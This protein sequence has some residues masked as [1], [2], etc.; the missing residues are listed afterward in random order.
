MD[1]DILQMENTKLQDI[2]IQWSVDVSFGTDL[3]STFAIRTW[4]HASMTRFRDPISSPKYRWDHPESK[5]EAVG[6]LGDVR[7]RKS[8]R[9]SESEANS[10]HKHLA[11]PITRSFKKEVDQ[12]ECFSFCQ[13]SYYSAKAAKRE[14]TSQ[15]RVHWLGLF[16]GFKPFRMPLRRIEHPTGQ[17]DTLHIWVLLS[18]TGGNYA[19]TPHHVN[20]RELS[21]QH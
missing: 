13:P 8:Y 3:H 15:Y 7:G 1:G 16:K 19:A 4:I 5:Q 12:L 10:C 20:V 6:A 14:Q 21:N 17:G 2:I 11:R 9:R 18:T